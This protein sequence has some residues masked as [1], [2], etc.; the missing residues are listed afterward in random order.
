MQA[1]GLPLT[2][3]AGFRSD[4]RYPPGAL[5][6]PRA[7]RRVADYASPKPATLA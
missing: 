7:L 4:M 3:G 1:S 5:T 2:P 6:D